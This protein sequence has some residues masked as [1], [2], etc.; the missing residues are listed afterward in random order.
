[1]GMY[2]IGVPLIYVMA[3]VGILIVSH[4]QAA[5][6]GVL[7]AGMI[8]YTM[9]ATRRMSEVWLDGDVFLVKRRTASF[10]VPLNEVLLL[11]TQ[12]GRGRQ[13]VLRLDHPVDGI[14]QVRFIPA[15]GVVEKDLQARIHAAKTAR[16]ASVP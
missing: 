5:A 1:M 6:I 4:G 8:G 7:F 14:D 12:F 9:W 10:R 16:K 15:I 11:E 3:Y 2:R 13:F